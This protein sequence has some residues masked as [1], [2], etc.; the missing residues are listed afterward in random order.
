MRRMLADAGLEHLDPETA[1]FTPLDALLPLAG[2]RVRPL[3][4]ASNLADGAATG[5]VVQLLED[6]V[7]DGHEVMFQL[8][9][10]ARL[11]AWFLRSWARGSTEL[12][13]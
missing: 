12:S 11:Y 1:G 13:R 4:I 2:A 3:P 5:A 7:E 9:E 8:P 10:A 6:G